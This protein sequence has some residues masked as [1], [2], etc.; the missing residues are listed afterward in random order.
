[1][2]PS[3][4]VKCSMSD[5]RKRSVCRPQPHLMA[6]I[7]REHPVEW[8]VIRCYAWEGV[9]CSESVYKE[10]K[11]KENADISQWQ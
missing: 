11:M 4:G 10:D 3:P 9:G 6:V 1:M 8:Q 2:P 5:A 7:G